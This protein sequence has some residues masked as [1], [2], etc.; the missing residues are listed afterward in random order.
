VLGPGES[1]GELALLSDDEARTASAVALSGAETL[2]WRRPQ[3]E[4]LRATV[5]EFERFLI[6]V[7]AAK[8]RRL[9]SRLVEALHVPVETRVLRRVADLAELHGGT[10][11]PVE[12]PVTQEDLASMAGTTR[13]TANRVLKEAE[14]AGMIELGRGKVI[15]SDQ[16]ALRRRAGI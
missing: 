9:S 12:V 11:G 15:V 4:E 3:V 10:D 16:R 13:P 14:A 7:L 8:V 2:S 5:P 6:E 1:F